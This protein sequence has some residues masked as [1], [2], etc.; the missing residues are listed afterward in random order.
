MVR[1]RPASERIIAIWQG[2]IAPRSH[3][4]WP[5]GNLNL[6]AT[7]ANFFLATGRP[8]FTL[9]ILGQ[10][11]GRW[12]ISSTLKP[13]GVPNCPGNY[14]FPQIAVGILATLPSHLPLRI[15][16]DLMV[17]GLLLT[18]FFGSLKAKP[19][20]KAGTLFLI[21]LVAW[22]GRLW[23][24]GLRTDSLMFGPLRIAQVVSLVGIVLD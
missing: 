7:Q 4:W 20:L 10:A 23:I 5:C 18:L 13:S 16:W 19:R 14:L 24:E 1:I 2:G 15:T 17:F 9:L 3:P 6:R 11:I 21:Y 8:C 12:G 22:Q